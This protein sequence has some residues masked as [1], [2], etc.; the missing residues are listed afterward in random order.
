MQQRQDEGQQGEDAGCCV[1]NGYG[2]PDHQPGKDVPLGERMVCQRDT[3][4]IIPVIE[5]GVPG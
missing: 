4:M 3:G 5:T 1:D 2:N